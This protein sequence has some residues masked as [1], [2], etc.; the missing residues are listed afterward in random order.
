MSRE[1]MV[2]HPAGAYT[3]D[4]MLDGARFGLE[5]CEE[6]VTDVHCPRSWAFRAEIIERAPPAADAGEAAP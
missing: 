4:V 3:H 6:I 2:V 1:V 5:R